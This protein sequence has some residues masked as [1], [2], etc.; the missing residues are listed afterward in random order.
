MKLPNS[1]RSVVDI[2]KLVSYCLSVEHPR[3]RH[4][5]RV[6]AEKLGFTGRDA[7]KLRAELLKAAKVEDAVIGEKDSYGQRYVLSCVMYGPKA[8]TTVRSH[9]IVR[10]G[11]DFPRFV[12]CYIQLKGKGK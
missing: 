7:E 12:T 10:N 2:E 4:K 6:F 8:K 5:A 1:E 11:E 3:G 9:W